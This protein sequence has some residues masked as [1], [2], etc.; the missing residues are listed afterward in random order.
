[1]SD[2]VGKLVWANWRSDGRDLDLWSGPYRSPKSEL[3]GWIRPKND[4]RDS[5]FVNVV[6]NT[7]LK[8]T[9]EL[10]GVSQEEAQRYL[11]VL[12]RME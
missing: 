10:D 6:V 2:G 11:E 12:C 1:M 5:W 4:N 7:N 9:H 3:R 8:E